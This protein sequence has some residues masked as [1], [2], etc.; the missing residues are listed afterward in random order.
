MRGR[1]L[2]ELGYRREGVEVLKK[3]FTDSGNY[4]ATQMRLAADEL[5]AS[6]EYALAR[7]G[8]ELAVKMA[9]DNTV[10]TIAAQIG[11]AK[12][13][14]AEGKFGE[15]A[16]A[17]DAFIAAHPTSFH[18]LDAN[19]LLSRAAAQAAFDEKD[20]NRRIKLFNRAVAA[21]RAVRP[22]KKG[23]KD[24][25]DIEMEVGRILTT[26]ADV[27]RKFDN[28]D[29]V[30]RYIGEAASHYQTFLMGSDKRNAELYPAIEIAYRESVKLMLEMKEYAD[31]T[32]VYEDVQ[33]ECEA[34][35]SLFP[36]GRFATDM[37]AFATEAAISL[38]TI[39]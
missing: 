24:L 12:I 33:S 29:L 31:G 39:R 19:L 35:L 21:I 13:L 27:E 20:R 37:R 8:F 22:Y 36:N 11:M 25:A 15:A 26:K 14:L 7:E 28:P 30:K 17:L 3:M 1:T 9:P 34:Y 38:S 5:L 32:P 18:V 6:Q 16:D 4:S 10:I 23:A 2:I